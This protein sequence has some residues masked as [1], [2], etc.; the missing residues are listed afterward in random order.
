MA[1]PIRLARTSALVSAACLTTLALAPIGRAQAPAQRLNR[2][3][4]VG[5]SLGGT[6]ALAVGSGRP[7]ATPA[8][9]WR[10]RRR[11]CTSSTAM[12]HR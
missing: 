7:R 9:A 3:I 8:A 5:H 1:V 6:L 2:P 12:P 4:V 11:A 10:T